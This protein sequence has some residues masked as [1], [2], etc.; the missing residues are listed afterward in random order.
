M[1]V[2]ILLGALG[3]GL[4]AFALVGALTDHDARRPGVL[5][6]LAAVLVGHDFVLLPAALLV[7]TAVTRWLPR[8]AR[9]PVLGGLFVT[10]VLAFVALP[11]ALGPGAPADNPS[12]LPRDYGVGLALTAAVVWSG[13]AAWIAGAALRRAR[14]G[15][16]VATPA[17]PGTGADT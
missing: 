3:V 8:P 14:R 5:V 17:D 16:G 6:V 11:L 10:A 1:T 2:R 4:M 12:V 13:V 15:P 7:G 9:T